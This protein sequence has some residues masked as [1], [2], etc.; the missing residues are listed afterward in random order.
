[1]SEEDPPPPISEANV[2][3]DA[4]L[5]F[6]FYSTDQINFMRTRLSLAAFTTLPIL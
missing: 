1:M 3:L 2:H 4:D 5:F 6:I